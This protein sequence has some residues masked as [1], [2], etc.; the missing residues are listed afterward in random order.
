MNNL[1]F[2]PQ[3]SLGYMTIAANRLLNAHLRRKMVQAGIDLTAEQWGVLVE[4]LNRGGLS[5]DELAQAA[6][7]DKSSM[8]RVLAGMERK[9]LI[10][11]QTDPADARRNI[12]TASDKADEIKGRSKSVAQGVLDLALSEVSTEDHLVC[13]KVLASV[14]KTLKVSGK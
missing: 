7:V 12:I 6:C 4:L 11:R 2:D 14:I 13:L 8:S 1:F 5:Q 3:Q 10:C 9:G